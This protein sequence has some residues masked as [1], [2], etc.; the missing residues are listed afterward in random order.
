MSSFIHIK[1]PRLRGSFDLNILTRVVYFLMV[2]IL[3]GNLLFLGWL[4]GP[5]IPAWFDFFLK[6]NYTRSGAPCG[7]LFFYVF[8]FSMYACAALVELDVK[9]PDT[10]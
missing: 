1:Q 4:A 8:D 7:P 9:I 3:G 6:Y 2:F 10:K 5:K